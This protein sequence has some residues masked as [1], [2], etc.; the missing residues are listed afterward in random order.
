MKKVYEKVALLVNNCFK[1][2]HK[3]VLFPNK[4]Y[5]SEKDS[6]EFLIIIKGEESK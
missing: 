1:N 4:I 3:G 5:Q 2:T 6:V